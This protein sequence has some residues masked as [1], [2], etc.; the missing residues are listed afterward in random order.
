M[1]RPVTLGRD[2][3]D[4]VEVQSGLAAGEAIVINPPSGLT[5]RALVRVK[6]S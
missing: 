2:R 6:G 5:D 3:L 1:R 4:Q